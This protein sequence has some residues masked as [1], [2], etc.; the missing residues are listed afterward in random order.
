MNALGF[1][2]SFATAQRRV[3]C[4]ASGSPVLS[5][6]PFRA[7]LLRSR[8][9]INDDEV[10]GLQPLQVRFLAYLM[11]NAGRVCTH[12][13]LAENIFGTARDSRSTSRARAVSILRARC[14]E[15]GRLIATIGGIGYGLGL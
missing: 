7:D 8:V 11:H 13:E 14:G 2:R 9:W 6:G 3:E 12:A 1:D 5:W 4:V 15:A 10:E